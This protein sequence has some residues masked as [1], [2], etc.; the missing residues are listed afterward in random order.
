M[1]RTW[2]TE[3][4]RYG[5]PSWRPYALRMT[6]NLYRYS[7]NYQFHQGRPST[8]QLSRLIH[9]LSESPPLPQKYHKGTCWKGTDK[10]SDPSS[11]S[12]WSNRQCH[13]CG[14]DGVVDVGPNPRQ[15][16]ACNGNG[17]TIEQHGTTFENI[18][19]PRQDCYHC[20]GTGWISG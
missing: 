20:G 15:C 1:A 10:L 11:S 14:G 4:F 16:G 2:Q 17:W 5:C 12:S 9:M 7:R 19:T 18:P 3:S 13:I 6:R 8:I